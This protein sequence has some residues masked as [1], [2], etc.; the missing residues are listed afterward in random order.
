[1]Q[2]NAAQAR[3]SETR[4]VDGGQT[5]PKAAVGA[6]DGTARIE[7]TKASAWSMMEAS[8]ERGNLWLAYQRVVENKGAAALMACAWMNS[9]TG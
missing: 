6:E 9:K 7:Q 8:V 4:A 2:F 3:A 5:S 1:M